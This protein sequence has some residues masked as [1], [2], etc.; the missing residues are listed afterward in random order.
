MKHVAFMLFLL[1]VLSAIGVGLGQSSSESIDA[2][3]AV[4]SMETIVPLAATPATSVAIVSPDFHFG[5]IYPG[6]RSKAGILTV[7]A[8]GAWQLTVKSVNAAAGEN[9]YCSGITAS[10]QNH[11]RVSV[12]D[13]SNN[14]YTNP[15][16]LTTISQSILSNQV[17]V[18]TA[19]D[20]VPIYYQ[21]VTLNDKAY[22]GAGGKYKTTITWTISPQT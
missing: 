20:I 18:T 8:N 15:L 12:K 22:G 7:T 14:Q 4:T 13:L 11:L 9:L 6:D 1:T 16:T 10:L 5:T 17:T 21:L 2:A 3:E 19:T